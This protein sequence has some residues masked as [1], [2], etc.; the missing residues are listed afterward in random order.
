[1]TMTARPMKIDMPIVMFAGFGRRTPVLS[2]QTAAF[3]TCPPIDILMTAAAE[4]DKAVPNVLKP[5][6]L[7]HKRWL[8][9]FDEAYARLSKP[10]TE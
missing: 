5:Q 4:A 10:P 9:A 3:A 6:T 8:K 7:A 1:M 2:S